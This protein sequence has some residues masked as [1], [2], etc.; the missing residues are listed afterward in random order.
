MYTNLAT[1]SSKFD[2]FLLYV[3]THTP[4][5]IILTETWLSSKDRNSTYSIPNYTLF[6]LDRKHRSRSEGGRMKGG[7]VAMYV[8][9]SV[10]GI[11]IVAKINKGYL[12]DTVEALYLDIQFH[13]Y[14][15]LVV[16]V[17][18]SDHGDLWKSRD[19][20]MLS[21]LATASNNNTVVIAGD[22]NYSDINW[23]LQLEQKINGA[24]ELFRNMFFESSLHQLVTEP[25]RFRSG[26]NPSL[27]DLVLTNDE[28]LISGI[29]Y[30]APIG[31]S[32]HCVIEFGIQCHVAPTKTQETLRRSYNKIDFESFNQD[33][34][35]E[36]D[37]IPQ[38]DDVEVS[39]STLQSR[40]DY[41]IDKHAP[42]KA[43]KKKLANKPWISSEVKKLAANK[44]LLWD[45]Y[46]TT[47]APSDYERYRFASNKCVAET[48]R[49]RGQYEA[50]I[51]DNGD[52]PFYSHIRSCMAGRVCVPPAVRN[53]NGDLVTLP[54][55][56]AE[57]FVEEFQKAY[58]REPPIMQQPE[59][60]KLA[61]IEASLCD[62]PITEDDVL[63]AIK[64]LDIGSSSGPDNIPGLILKNCA[65][66]LASFLT[67]I[68][69]LSLQTGKV[70]K[71]WKHAI[72]TPIFKNGDKT[73]PA[74]FRPISLTCIS[75]KIMERIICNKL[76]QFLNRQNVISVRQHGFVEKRSTVTNLLTSVYAWGKELDNRNPVD[77]IYL[78]FERA[79]DKVPHQRLLIKLEHFGIR[80]C[81]LDWIKD[82]LKDRT[83]QVRVGTS[84]SSKRDVLSGVPQG[85][86]LAPTLFGIFVTD[87]V[88]LIESQSCFF[89]DDGKFFGNPLSEANKL[90]ADINRL[91]DW[92]NQWIV[93]LNIAKC[94]VLHMGTNNP[95]VDY[96]IDRQIIAATNSQKDLGVLMTKDLKWGEHINTI[97]KK[98]N[99]FLYVI[100]RSFQLI[101]TN[102]FLKIYKTYI[103][104]LLEYAVQ[105]WNPYLAKDIDLLESVQRRATK[106]PYK[107]R[108]KS[109]GKRLE[110]LHLTTL[111][112]RRLRGDLIET[113]K[114]LTG[115]Y[116]LPIKDMFVLKS[117]RFQRGHSLKL[118]RSHANTNV[119]YHFLTNRIVNVWNELPADVVS[120]P[121]VNSFKNRLDNW[122]KNNKDF[123]NNNIRVCV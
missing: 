93:K 21:N 79:F 41:T 36:L 25:T 112:E 87:L 72:V 55:D 113:Y 94:S 56:I 54:A 51:L 97:V 48:R 103:R 63:K 50:K 11:P 59:V 38:S 77:V 5:I 37:S 33:L 82:Y 3:N 12:I 80:G 110:I 35:C 34:V 18:R 19:P 20:L 117:S 29:S 26:Q 7:G 101:T 58:S 42:L 99:S 105:V 71:A 69:N 6:R 123:I 61:R 4:S 49:R 47:K 44:K 10:N 89:A 73:D 45:T 86:V 68:M 13:S 9:D 8:R 96:T 70:P 111:S 104:P 91:L 30:H 118:N 81:L 114:I 53:S 65:A 40:I 16:G 43:I 15:F 75:C 115:Q 24:D 119:A 107:L 100:K 14:H 23:P 121:S 64:N 52:K 120:A 39:W 74:K 116:N 90:Q 2:L 31:K 83:F 76:T 88:G 27:L 85:S 108:K 17:Y 78:D 102:V 62:F 22:F 98:A 28:H 67:D 109:Y 57:A 106:I 66:A 1:L 60:D 92:T 95:Q 122:C 32:D 46:M 84:L